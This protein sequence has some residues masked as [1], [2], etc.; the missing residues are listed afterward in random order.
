MNSEKYTKLQ[1]WLHG[2][3][4]V[5]II[6]LSASGFYVGQLEEGV[7]I[8]SVVSNF[9]IALA[10][11]F[12]PVFIFR[13]FVALSRPHVFFAEH[14]NITEALAFSVHVLLYLTT[15]IALVSGVLM[16]NKAINVFGFFSIEQPLS[17]PAVTHLF[18]MIHEASCLI[19]GVLVTLH[20][21][22]VIK[23][24]LFGASVFR[25]MFL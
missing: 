7:H 23:H 12:S 16:M 4:A 3:S 1:K 13:L 18:F 2:I 8:K 10:A 14:K 20:V 19:L 22:A 5:I 21:M 11:V 15:M 24:Q 6:W 9:N 17:D 25:R